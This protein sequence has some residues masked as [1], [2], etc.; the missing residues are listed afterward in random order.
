[1][2]ALATLG[3]LVDFVMFVESG[4]RFATL[5]KMSKDQQEQVTER[6]RGGGEE[7]QKDLYSN[8]RLAQ[9]D[10]SHLILRAA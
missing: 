9:E 1:M 3:T 5:I 6:Q 8:G 4:A 10:V 2:G 7:N